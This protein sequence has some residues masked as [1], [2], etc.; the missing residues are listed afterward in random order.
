MELARSVHCSMR[1]EEIDVK[2][3]SLIAFLILAV[4]V[5][6]AGAQETASQTGQSILLPGN[7]APLLVTPEV[8]LTSPASSVGGSNATAGCA[9]GA[10]NQTVGRPT[11]ANNLG[12]VPQYAG[13]AYTVTI[14]PNPATMQGA[15]PSTP[16][17]HLGTVIPPI[18]ATSAAA[19]NTVGATNVTTASPVMPRS[20]ST[21]PE[22]TVRGSTVLII[23]PPDAIPSAS[24]SLAGEMSTGAQQVVVSGR[25]G[26]GVGQS[27]DLVTDVNSREKS[28]GAVA[29][30]FRRSRSASSAAMVTNETMDQAGMRSSARNRT[31]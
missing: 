7:G 11:M 6:S 3:Q 21:V 30:E 29:L 17:V 19:G 18:G 4:L 12:A 8:H 26:L 16:E 22:F 9:A 27:A 20:T 28:L 14:T 1:Y 10:T 15:A 23:P 5:I 13:P 31:Q 2:P 25:V 24:G